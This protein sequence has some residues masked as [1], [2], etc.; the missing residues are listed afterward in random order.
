LH[1]YFHLDAIGV[2][3]LWSQ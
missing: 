3:I 2:L 1:V